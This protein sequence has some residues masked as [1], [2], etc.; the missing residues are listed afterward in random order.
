MIAN[1]RS[2]LSEAMDREEVEAE[3]SGYLEDIEQK[4][5]EML[6]N[7]QQWTDQGYDDIVDMSEEAE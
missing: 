4:R 2:D 1:V 7:L 6:D 5:D 3:F